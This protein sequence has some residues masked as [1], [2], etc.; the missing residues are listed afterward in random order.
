MPASTI[1]ECVSERER[2][3]YRTSLFYDGSVTIIHRPPGKPEDLTKFPFY[4]VFVKN[5]EMFE[6]IKI[7]M[8]FDPK[9]WYQ[10]K[11]LSMNLYRDIGLWHILLVLNKCRSEVD[12]IGT[13]VWYLDPNEV[14]EYMSRMFVNE[15]IDTTIYR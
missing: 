11:K 9:F 3:P 4:N 12:F 7:Q 1:R 10:P 6:P 15:N 5:R 14:M 2:S 13:K 8:D